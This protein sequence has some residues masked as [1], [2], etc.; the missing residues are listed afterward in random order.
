ML[1][2]LNMSTRFILLIVVSVV[3]GWIPAAQAQHVGFRTVESRP[4]GLVIEISASWPMGLKAGLDSVKAT[5]LTV[6]AIRALTGGYLEDSETYELPALILPHVQILA[7]EY[8]E[9]VISADAATSDVIAELQKTIVDVVGLGMVRK[10]PV[11]TLVARLLTYDTVGQSLRRYRRIRVALS[12]GSP[13]SEGAVSRVNKTGSIADNPHLDIDRSVLADGIVYKIPVSREGIYRIDREYLAGLTDLGLSPEDIEPDNLK[14]FGNGGAPVPAI[15]NAPR[16][17][18]IVENPVYV[19]GGG[20]GSFDSGDVLLFYAAAPR[21]WQYNVSDGIWEHYVHPFTNE[22]FYFLKIGEDTEGKRVGLEAFPDYPDAQLRAQVTGRYVRDLDEFMWSKENGTGYTWVSRTIRPGNSRSVLDNVILPG[23]EGGDVSIDIRVAIRS[24]PVATLG[25]S[26][27]GTQLGSIT[28]SRTTSQNI[29]APIAVPDEKSFV[30]QQN[31]AAPLSLNMQ[32]SAGALNVPEAAIDWVRIFFPQSL[33]ADNDTL[34]FTTPPGETGRFELSLR[35]FTSEPQVW[36]V[37]EPDAIRRLNV[38][39]I[40]EAY[41]IQ[42]E[43]VDA[44]TP[45]ELFAFVEN[46]STPV[47]N[48]TTY[49]IDNQDLHAVSSYPDFVIVTPSVFREQAEELAEMRR[50]DGLNVIVTDVDRIYNEFSGGLPDMRAVRDYLKFIYDRA[51]DENSLLRYALLFG[52]GHYNFRSLGDETQ[53]P[54]LGNWIFPFATAESFHPDR[55]YTSDDYFGLLDDYEGEWPYGGYSSPAPS[56]AL[57]ERV[58]LG[59]GRLTVQTPEE[60]AGIVQKIRH[61]ESPDTYGPWRTRYTF[62]ADDAYNGLSGIIEITPDLHTQNSDVVAELVKQL[63]PDINIQK[64]YGISYTRQFLNGWRLPAVERD[65]KKALNDGVLAFNYSGHGG[66][67]GLA[68]EGILTRDDAQTLQNLDTLP[69]FITATCSFGWWDLANEQSAAEEFLLNQEGGA[70]ALLTTVRLVYTSPSIEILN[71]G[72]N[73]YLNMEMF[74]TDEEGRPRRLGDILRDTKNTYAGLQGNNRKFNLLGDPTLR[75]GLPPGDTTIDRVNNVPID[76]QPLISAL[77]RVT[78]SGSVRDRD[79]AIDSG[80]QGTVN[81]TVF[82]SERRVML[83]VQNAMP[84]PYYTVREDLIWRGTVPAAGGLFEATFVV[85]KDISYSNS[86][87]RIVAYAV[88]EETQATGFTENVIVGGT[89]ATPPDDDIGP[90]IYL[91]L[92]D[93]TFVSGGLTAPNPLLI[94]KLSDESGINTVGAGVGHEM[95][96]VVDGDEQNAIDIN[97]NYESEANSY[98]RGRVDFS[99]EGYPVE[100]ASGPHTA[101]VRAWD[102]LNNSSTETIDFFISTDEKLVLRN[103]YNYPNPTSG[104]TRFVFEH[105][106]PTGTVAEVLVRIYTLAGRPVRTIEADEALPSGVL[107]GGPV[108]VSWDGRDDDFDVLASGI[109]LYKLKVVVEGLDGERKV[110]EQIEKLAIIR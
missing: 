67:E 19:N 45:R 49:R 38:R 65:I 108:Q 36:D 14:I 11:A 78:V 8:D 44:A 69:I 15:N 96:L 50:S 106:Q 40:G 103:V 80:F 24:N 64:I 77:D 85:P 37:T 32:F 81:I 52:D 109:Y 9:Y 25:F 93:T 55:S 99:F 72:L 34:R 17:A 107:T 62:V 35:G 61:Y 16:L 100:L 105:N 76:Q 83:P 59:I 30:F 91:F 46:A 75:I 98:Q 89:S 29:D 7:S 12:Y 74:E 4:D 90:E 6:D 27:N 101:S 26:V 2:I 70:I 31:T 60:A 28:A 87:G 92:N 33:R 41:D 58:D 56:D 21:G 110:S 73:R 68:Q 88:S 1:L 94:V 57:V 53:R 10:Q 5:R 86:P 82:D 104:R 3:L 47:D 22:N 102:V 48:K 23:F 20:D 84:T 63:Y 51:P 39:R 42:I 43:V 13:T 66:E 71:V 97:Q 79:G 54:E 95:L 18:D